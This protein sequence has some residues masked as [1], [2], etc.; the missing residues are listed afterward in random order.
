MKPLAIASVGEST[1]DHYVDLQQQ[2]VGGISLNFAVHC[3]RSGADNVSL[4]SR[5]GKEDERRILQKLADEKVDSSHVKTLSGSTARQDVQLAASG[6]R[7]F[8]AGGYDPGVLSHFELSESEIDFIRS[9][10]VLASSMFQQLE[11][12]FRRVMSLP[13]D[14]WR[15]A[16]FLDLG[17]YNKD[18][19]VVE[20]WI[21]QLAVAFIS[22]DHDLV[23][24]LR[25]LSRAAKCL[26]VI[27]LGA[28]GSAALIKGDPIFQP[29]IKVTKTLDSTGCGDAFQASFT[30]SYWR[31]QNVP[32]A[33]QAGAR[34]ASTVIQHY[35]A[36]G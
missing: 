34:Q 17:D 9:R 28:D 23:E 8:P 21:E 16:D 24:N 20:E 31:E 11:P 5:I 25:P 2:F 26:L 12:L 6:D 35:G 18:V 15:V 19:G 1:I 27:T 10:N 3:K 13:F 32:R 36:T 4:I 29:S 7:V 30:V 33:L 14:G 22:G